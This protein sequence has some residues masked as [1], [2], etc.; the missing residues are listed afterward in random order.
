MSVVA[1]VLASM[2]AHAGMVPITGVTAKSYYSQG[3]SSYPESKVNDGKT[4][5]WFEGDPGN[6][7]GSWIEVN[8]GSDKKVSKIVMFAGDWQSG[9]NWRQ[10]NRPKEIEIKWADGTTDTWTLTDE[11]KPQAFVPTAP[12]VTSTI[13]FK[14]NSLY[15]GTTFPDTAISEIQVYDDQ[16]GATATVTG[17]KASSE[18]PSDAD[19]SYAAAQA[20][21]GVKDTFWCEGNKAGDGVGEWV[22]VQFD[23][24]TP[25]KGVKICTGM[26]TTDAFVRGNAPSKV[27]LQ[28]S[29]GSVQH[30][31]LKTA[32][33]LPSPY[34][35]TP[36]TTSSVKVTIEAVRKGTE[37][38]DA[39]LSELTFDR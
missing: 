34:P 23:A 13:R 38:N 26:C 2:T 27:A 35:I 8:L 39:C 16:P 11:W 18:S 5:P 30:L 1:L 3:G 33:P 25:I 12:K 15:S 9:E 36:V 24:A 29:D 32:A 7:V 6:G 31:D 4:I 10:A 22:Q 20:A 28:F 14:M 19:G 21:D 37:F 17:V